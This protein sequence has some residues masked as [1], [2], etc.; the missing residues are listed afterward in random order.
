[1]KL[2]G[3]TTISINKPEPDWWSNDQGYKWGPFNGAA[4]Y[5]ASIE[6]TPDGILRVR[7]RVPGE[8]EVI[9]EAPIVVPKKGVLNVSL[10]WDV[11]DGYK[12]MLNG[13]NPV[14]HPLSPLG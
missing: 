9:L 2:S 6:K 8:N 10:G 3:H 5:E 4:S 14:H 1:M 13:L 7:L 11:N 12:M